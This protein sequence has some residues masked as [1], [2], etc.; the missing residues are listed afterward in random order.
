MATVKTR[1][2][3]KR[4]RTKLTARKNPRKNE[5][6]EAKQNPGGSGSGRGGGLGTPSRDLAEAPPSL[7]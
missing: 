6:E 1:T 5:L 3:L 7:D 2:M 4:A